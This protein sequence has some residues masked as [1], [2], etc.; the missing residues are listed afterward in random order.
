MR[1]RPTFSPFDEPP[2]LNQVSYR[3]QDTRHI[4][5]HVRISPLDL[6]D[7][8]VLISQGRLGGPDTTFLQYNNVEDDGK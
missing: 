1:G 3:V 2:P 8:T 6:N 4:Q 7:F 5:T